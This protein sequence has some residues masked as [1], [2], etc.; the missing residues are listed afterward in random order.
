MMDE[1]S[2]V[3]R[4]LCRELSR[5]GINPEGPFSAT[6]IPG[7][8]WT[9]ASDELEDAAASSSSGESESKEQANVQ[10]RARTK[11]HPK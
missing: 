2:R 11:V 5:V 4:N 10:A 9:F 1:R 8:G 7:E 3:I 6:F